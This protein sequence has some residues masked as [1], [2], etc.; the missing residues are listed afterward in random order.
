MVQF[1]SKS[2]RNLFCRTLYRVA[3]PRA[4]TD[5]DVIQYR[6]DSIFVLFAER[7][8]MARVTPSEGSLFGRLPNAAI[9]VEG[10]LG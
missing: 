5:F 6:I 8:R 2:I 1:S 7:A 9:V 4:E 10:K 3:T